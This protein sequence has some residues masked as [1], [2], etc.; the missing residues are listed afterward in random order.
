MASRR[1]V[2]LASAAVSAGLLVG[3]CAH[4]VP[5]P[6]TL[7]DIHEVVLRWAIA[8]AETNLSPPAA[9]CVGYTD[10]Q[11]VANPLLLEDPSP[12]LLERLQTLPVPVRPVS[13][14]RIAGNGMHAVVDT[15]TNGYGLLFGVGPPSRGSD[16]I[17]TPVGF[18]QGREWGLGWKCELRESAGNLIVNRCEVMFHI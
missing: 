15:L 11:D 9:Y 3:S 10:G 14:C 7:T 18:L 13:G 5:Q 4:R 6:Q 2:P 16:H 17:T 12:E 1:A 8:N